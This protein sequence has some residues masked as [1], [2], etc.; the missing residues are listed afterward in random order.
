MKEIITA[1][2]NPK[3]NNKLKEIKEF[4]I[5]YNDIQYQDGVL[6]ILK[7]NTN[8]EILIL[9]EILP[10]ELKIKEFIYEIKK[11]NKD[12]KIIIFLEKTKEDFSTLNI[13][14]FEAEG[15]VV[16]LVVKG[17]EE[18]VKTTLQSMDPLLLDVLQVNFEELF[19]YELEGRGDIHE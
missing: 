18:E 17:D 10:G 2:A 5:N 8:I 3:L 6:E 19:I 4:N 1:L 12:I 7:E 11:Y 16:K 9:S 14:H 15:R 13:L